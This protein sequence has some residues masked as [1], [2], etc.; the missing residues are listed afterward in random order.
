M[1]TLWCQWGYFVKT[2]NSLDIICQYV[3]KTKCI[4]FVI[5]TK[6][7]ILCIHLIFCW[8]SHRT[9]II[10]YNVIISTIIT[11]I[12]LFIVY[13]DFLLSVRTHL[14][15]ILM[16]STFMITHVIQCAWC[17]NACKILRIILV[18]YF[19]NR[20]W[21]KIGKRQ[22]MH[23]MHD[24]VHLFQQWW[25]CQQHLRCTGVDI[26]HKLLHS[27]SLKAVQHGRT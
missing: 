13:I 15:I 9:A 3:G 10:L 8:R 27:T 14:H 23:M 18:S 26:T 4:E 21:Q 25:T 7:I 5:G 6:L 16:I 20:L 1:C 19:I 11:T 17:V 22:F 12:V 24:L 2:V